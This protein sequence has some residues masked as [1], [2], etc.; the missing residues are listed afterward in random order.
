MRRKNKV[1]PRRMTFDD[2]K[3]MR[4]NYPYAVVDAKDN[5]PAYLCE[6]EE[7]AKKIVSE[8]RRCNANV[9]IAID[10]RKDEDDEIPKEAC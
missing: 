6:D 4:N 1:N 3:K 10:L 2:I 7:A 8:Q 9:Y 5:T